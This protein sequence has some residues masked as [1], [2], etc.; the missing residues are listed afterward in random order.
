MKSD[1]YITDETKES[2][3]MEVPK[4]RSLLYR[5]A[6]I[7]VVVALLEMPHKAKTLR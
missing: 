6:P 1:D 5:Y 7:Y 4:Q 2:D 3:W